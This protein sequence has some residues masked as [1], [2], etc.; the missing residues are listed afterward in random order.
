MLITYSKNNNKHVIKVSHYVYL[1]TS[2]SDLYF[3]ASLNLYFT[4]SIS[5]YFT[6]SLGLYFTA[7]LGMHFNASLDLFYFLIRFIFL[8][9]EATCLLL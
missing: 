2:S 7:S 1:F 4:A 5:L 6:T 9:A 8:P 3:T